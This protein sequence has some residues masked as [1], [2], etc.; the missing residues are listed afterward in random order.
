VLKKSLGQHL[1][2]DKNLLNKLVRLAGIGPEDMVVEI[3]PGQGD[4]TKAIASVA[5]QVRAVELDQRFV[6][7]YLRPLEEEYEEV[8]IVFADVLDVRIADYFGGRKVT[9]MGNIPYN[10][11]GEILFKLLAE[12]DVVDKAFLTMQKEVAERVVS[13]SH[14]RSYGAVSVIFQLYAEVKILMTMKAALFIPP[15]KVDSAFLAIRFREEPMDQGL[16][17][18]VKTC[19][20]YKRKYLRHALEERFS[21]EAVGGLYKAM[22][23][24][25]TIRAEEIEPEGFKTMYE[26]MSQM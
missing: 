5:K 2:K 17:D 18:F 25:L 20:H 7:H 19:F 23:F 1:L 8:K 26:H 6:E 4:L 11:T 21:P 3:G 9:V 13:K 22:A 24:P 10:I 16:I 14:A 12:K 15:P